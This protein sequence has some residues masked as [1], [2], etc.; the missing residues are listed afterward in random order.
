[1]AEHVIGTLADFP[2]GTHKIVTLRNMQIGVFNIDGKLHALPNVCAHQFGPLCAGTV[3]GT[4]VC[5]EGTGWLHSWERGGEI[6]TCPWHGIEF[7]ITTGVSLSSKKL[8]VRTYQVAVE[9]DE[10]K[11]IL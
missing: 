3:N 11:I 7:D 9:G 5:N 6:V 10:V 4:F 1:L 2:V 8:K